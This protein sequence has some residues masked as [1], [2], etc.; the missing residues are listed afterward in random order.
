MMGEW[1]LES[2]QFEYVYLLRTIAIFL[3]YGN[4]EPQALRTAT[5]QIGVLLRQHFVTEVPLHNYE[6]LPLSS[7]K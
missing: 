1:V 2:Q 5:K 4:L 3:T 6:H 7:S